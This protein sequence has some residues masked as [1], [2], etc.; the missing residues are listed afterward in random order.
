[1][2]LTQFLTVTTLLFITGASADDS[3]TSEGG[4]LEP[5]NLKPIVTRANVLLRAGQFQ[6]AAKSYSDAIE[7]SPADYH[8]YYM[9][10][11]AYFSLSR[12]PAALDDVETV[13]KMTEGSFYKAFMMRARILTKEGEWARARTELKRFTDKAGQSD[14]DAQDLVSP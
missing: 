8:L 6:D 1:M 14:K 11:S 3:P 4:S 9:R 12:H 7:L 2:R 5:P 10:A 13:L